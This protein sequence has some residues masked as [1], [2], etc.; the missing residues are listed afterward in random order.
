MT[1]LLDRE[2]IWQL[3]GRKAGAHTKMRWLSVVA[4]TH[5]TMG[6]WRSPRPGLTRW[7]QGTPVQLV[8]KWCAARHLLSST[9]R[10]VNSR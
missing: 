4:G 3:P 1:A 6:D 8:T 7:E 2:G 10:C 9:S 5:R